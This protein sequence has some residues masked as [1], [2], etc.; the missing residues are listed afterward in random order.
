M[1]VVRASR[2]RAWKAVTGLCLLACGLCLSPALAADRAL[3]GEFTRLDEPSTHQPGKVRVTEFADFFCPHC[4]MFEQTAI[5]LLQREFGDRVEVD[6]V[7]YPVIPGML[8]TPF[9]MYE[10]AKLMGKGDAMK[11]ALF[12]TIHRDKIVMFDRTVRAVLA[13]E[14]GLDPVAFEAGLASGLPAEAFK[15]GRRWGERVGISSTPTVVLD[16][17]IKLE[18]D[19]LTP[20]NLKT[21]IRSI[22]DA[23]AKG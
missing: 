16:G 10:Q 9:I 6:M 13:S 20:D 12:R 4:H 17:N 7:G 1:K 18:G 5:P 2:R 22:L 11:A 8:P 15:E 14:V 19:H 21:V 23:D 3:E